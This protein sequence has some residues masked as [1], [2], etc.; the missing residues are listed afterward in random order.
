MKIKGRKSVIGL[1]EPYFDPPG[2]ITN[3]VSELSHIWGLGGKD[4]WRF[5][6]MGGV[7]QTVRI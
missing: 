3:K 2:D 7:E 5:I 1:Q 4:E 6:F